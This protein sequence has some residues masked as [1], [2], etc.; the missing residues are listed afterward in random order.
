MPVNSEHPDYAQFKPD[1]VLLRDCY[2]GERAVKDKGREYLPATPGM[3]MDGM[4]RSTDPGLVAYEAY[5][6]RAQFPDY[7]Q[8]GVETLVGILNAKPTEIKLPAGMEYLRERATTKGEKLES[9]LRRMHEQ[10]CTTGRLGLLADM[11][12]VPDL[13]D[14][15]PYLALYTA[16]TIIN[17]D[18]GEDGEGNN[19][20]NL[21]VLDE[22][23]NVRQQDLTWQ[24]GYKYR[25]LALGLLGPNEQKGVYKQG[26]F[27]GQSPTY[28]DSDMQAPMLRGKTLDEIP[29]VFF[30]SKDNLV[31]P[32]TPPLLGLARLCM[33]IYRSEADYR[34]AL[35]LQAQD[36]LVIVGGTSGDKDTPLRVG[37]GA[38]I[39]TSIGGDA[40]FIGVGS[41][42]L[43]EQRTAIENDR[44]AAAVRTGQLLAPG[45]M[46]MESGEALKTRVAAQ[47]ATLTS[48]A[49]TAAQGL[50][51]ILRLI[52][53]WRGENP[54]DVKV[55]PNLDFTNVE[56][57]GQDIVQL[58]TAKN[59][60][61]PLSAMSLHKLARERGLTTM[62]F[63]EEMSSIKED[64]KELKEW[65]EKMA[66][67]LKGN[68]AL[69]A[70][71]GPKKA[72]LDD[73]TGASN[74]QT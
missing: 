46:S 16:E 74:A 6:M 43:S 44:K 62:T 3:V 24:L 41:E 23:S 58:T 57:A 60:G 10:Q 9:L 69:E 63:E 40:K 66:M 72:P 11:D 53:I 28:V 8:V 15:K 18:D 56:I 50:E 12:K 47:T 37:A 64:P 1:W 27:M 36:T 30:N 38:K 35:Y 21:V 52:A 29:F 13:V 19:K 73:K 17:W 61:F 25:V 49:K 14:P 31:S 48:V 54:N 5:K 39:E 70:A 59:L 55:T 4:L 33:S 42:G 32:D 26:V 67:G 45:K 71:G 68:N 65:A 7:M 34:Q 20:L 2:A 22:S 51:R